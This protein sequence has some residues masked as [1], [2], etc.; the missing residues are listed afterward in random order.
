MSIQDKKT[1]FRAKYIQENCVSCLI[2]TNYL[3][4]SLCLYGRNL[5]IVLRFDSVPQFIG[6]LW[7]LNLRLY[8]QAAL[9][10]S[11]YS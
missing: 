4:F 3:C 2:W 10:D 1:L 7:A 9:Q 11:R 5:R 6:Y 8:G